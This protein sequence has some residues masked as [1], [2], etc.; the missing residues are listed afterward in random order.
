MNLY[1]EIIELVNFMK[2]DVTKFYEKGNKQ[3][4]KRARQSLQDLKVL[5]QE[6]RVE[7]QDIK[8]RN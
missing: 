1:E 7:I 8:N 6:M 4:G 2:E 3:A 5:C